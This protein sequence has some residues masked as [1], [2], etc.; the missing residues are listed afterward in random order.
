MDDIRIS[1]DNL[2]MGPVPP[3]PKD[4]VVAFMDRFRALEARQRAYGMHDPDCPVFLGD[5]AQQR[6]P[7]VCYTRNEV[8]DCWLSEE[9]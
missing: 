1:T 6:N 5:K 2:T 8:C 4:P 9:T 7:D 3:S